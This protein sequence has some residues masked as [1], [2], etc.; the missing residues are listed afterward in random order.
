M[1]RPSKREIE[2]ALDEVEEEASLEWVDF[3]KLEDGDAEPEDYG[4]TEDDARREW[5]EFVEASGMEPAPEER[6]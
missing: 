4:L 6:R 3:I 1:T 2:E 5:R